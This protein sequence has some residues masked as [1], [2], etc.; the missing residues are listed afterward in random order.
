VVAATSPL[1]AQTGGPV[2]AFTGATLIDGT[3]RAPIANATL[4]VRNGRIVAA[5]PAA[6][7]KVPAD[8][9][10]VALDGK[11]IIPGLINAHGHAS[12]AGNL[13]TYAAYGVTTVYSLG[14]ETPEVFAAR[15]AQSIA[16][17]SHARVYV[18][19]PV[20]TPTTPEEARTQVEVVVART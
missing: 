10:R 13:A 14:D 1:V 19:G 4:V 12:S 7:V 9:E 15:D 17:P 18:A 2:R 11:T 3:T 6:A 8:A 16:P 5:G 20:L